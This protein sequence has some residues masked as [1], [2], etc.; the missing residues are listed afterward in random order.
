MV[1]RVN[2]GAAAQVNTGSDGVVNL[3][4]EQNWRPTG[5]MRGSLSGQAAAAYG[6]LI[7]QPTQPAPAAAPKP[8]ATSSLPSVPPPLQALRANSRNF[9]VP[10]TQNNTQPASVNGNSGTLP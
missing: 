9:Y 10:Q 1:Q 4:S 8:P 7:I 6:D 2:V 3:P 5:R